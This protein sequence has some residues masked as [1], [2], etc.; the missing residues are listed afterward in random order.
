MPGSTG[1][2]I[3]RSKYA[4]GPFGSL[5]ALYQTHQTMPVF[6]DMRIAAG[7]STGLGWGQDRRIQEGGVV[8]SSGAVFGGPEEDFARDEAADLPG[9]RGSAG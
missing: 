7:R 8:R 9:L 3:N 1:I 6:R 2:G 4:V 5:S